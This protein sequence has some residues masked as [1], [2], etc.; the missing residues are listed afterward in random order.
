MADGTFAVQA[1]LNDGET[2][3]ASINRTKLVANCHGAVDFG[4]EIFALLQAGIAKRAY[5]KEHPGG[6][7]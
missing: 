1:R 5:R 4:D 6:I 2:V 7:S 3:R